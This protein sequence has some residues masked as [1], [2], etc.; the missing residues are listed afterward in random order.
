MPKRDKVIVTL[1]IGDQ[2]LKPWKEI[3]E[4]NW[5]QYADRYGFD[6]VCFTEPL[7]TSERARKRSPSWQKCLVLGQDSI[8]EYERV[9]WIDSDM[10]INNVGAPCVTDAVPVEK[11]GAV[12]MYVH[13][14]PDLH[15]AFLERM[16]EYWGASAIRN[17]TAEEYYTARGMP[18]GVKESL[19]NAVMV[20]SPKWHREVLEKVYYEYDVKGGKTWHDEMPPTSYE[21]CR[22]NSVHW[23]DG[24]FIVDWSEYMFLHYPF[25]ILPPKSTGGGLAHMKKQLERLIGRPTRRRVRRACVT[26][27]L[28]NSYFLHFGGGRLG[29]MSF[30]D[31]TARS[32]QDCAL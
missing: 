20:L 12:Q 24:R 9:V 28:L 23:I 30:V 2:Y 16:F 17:L 32:F 19:Y 1:A 31:F 3:C 14:T 7:D 27:A 21:L 22:S 18:G 25:L 6:L 8:R 13:P 26:T 11:V 29:D 10:L 5:R 15:V 4:A